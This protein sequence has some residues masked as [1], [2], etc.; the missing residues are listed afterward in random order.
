MLVTDP[1]TGNRYG[2]YGYGSFVMVTETVRYDTERE[3]G[4]T[5]EQSSVLGTIS[6][7]DLLAA[8]KSSLNTAQGGHSDA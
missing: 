7:C 3:F 6:A 1:Q 2:L 5:R 8:I 4:A